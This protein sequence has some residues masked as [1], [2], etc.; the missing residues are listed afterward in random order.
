MSDHCGTTTEE[1]SDV[2]IPGGCGC[3]SEVQNNET[4]NNTPKQ[5]IPVSSDPSEEVDHVAENS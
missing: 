3:S 2:C 4:Q 1:G 5:L